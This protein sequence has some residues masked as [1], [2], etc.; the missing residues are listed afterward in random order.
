MRYNN[1]KSIIP[2]CSLTI[3]WSPTLL[4]F[5]EAILFCLIEGLI[6][7]PAASPPEPA[8]ESSSPLE[9]KPHRDL[10]PKFQEVQ[11][12]LAT[13]KQSWETKDRD[14]FMDCYSRAFWTQGKGWNQWRAHKNNLNAIYREIRVSQDKAKMQEKDSQILVPFRQ[15]YHS[16][17]LKSTGQKKP[18]PEAGGELLED[19][20][21]KLPPIQVICPVHLLRAIKSHSME[22]VLENR[23]APPSLFGRIPSRSR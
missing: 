7:K 5:F 4:S 16:D 6:K 12:F 14:Q 13:W 11:A 3:D 17:G 10:A 1:W 19:H 15:S 8:T 22:D 2:F 20:P 23:F 21:R 18:Y 9:E